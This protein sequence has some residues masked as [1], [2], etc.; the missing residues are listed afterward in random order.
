MQ[1]A[2][3]L[4]SSPSRLRALASF[5]RSLR[6]G[7]LV[8]MRG[9]G[10]ACVLEG[11]TLSHHRRYLARSSSGQTFAQ[12]FGDLGLARSLLR[13][14]GVPSSSDGVSSAWKSSPSPS[15]AKGKRSA[16][17]A[18]VLGQRLKV[19]RD[20][21]AGTTI[22]RIR[23]RRPRFQQRQTKSRVAVVDRGLPRSFAQA[24]PLAVLCRRG[25]KDPCAEIRVASWIAVVPYARRPRRGSKETLAPLFRPPRK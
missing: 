9:V 8:S 17:K 3:L 7:R 6:Y 12:F 18:T 25:Q 5:H 10:L 2:L 22:S 11:I 14:Q 23:S 1:N 13:R 19:A 20:V 24:S 4:F 16:H 21:I 15:S